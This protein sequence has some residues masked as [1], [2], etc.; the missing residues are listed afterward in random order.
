MDAVLTLEARYR[1]VMERVDAAARRS[2]R[3]PADV[4][5]VAVSKYAGLDE[6]REL[7][8]LGHQDFG[9]SRAQQLVQR[10]AVVDEMLARRRQLPELRPGDASF[11]DSVRWHM[12]GHLQRN[13]VKK[14][15]PVVR[16]LHSVDS[17]RLVEELH[18][19]AMKKD[20]DID[21]L[22]QVN[23]SEELQKYG[24]QVAAAQAMCEQIDAT[25]HLHIR[26]LMTMAAQGETPDDSR[27][28][29]ERCAELFDDIRTTGIGDGRF[30]ILSM[31]MT[32]DFEVGIE[33]GSNLVRIGSAIFGEH[34][35]ND[36]D[37]DDDD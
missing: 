34:L 28:A 36:D 35:P 3:S 14:I 10:A 7:M 16:L 30:N 2:G 32:D 11:P 25:G 22:V 1:G 12:I 24:C 23:C 33:C 37:Q 5:V 4:M 6:V 18:T 31:G 15:A 8:R 20:L 13:K 29:F 17:L 27:P 19:F 26:G 9:E 21:V